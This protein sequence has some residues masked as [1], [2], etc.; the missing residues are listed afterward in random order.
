MG[1]D[2][3]IIESLVAEIWL[4]DFP[5]NSTRPSMHWHLMA[6]IDLRPPVKPRWLSYVHGNNCFS[7]CVTGLRKAIFSAQAWALQP[8][9]C[10]SPQCHSH[11]ISDKSEPHPH[12][13]VFQMLGSHD[14][15]HQRH[16]GR[17]ERDSGKVVWPHRPFKWLLCKFCWHCSSACLLKPSPAQFSEGTS[18][19][20]CH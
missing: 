16:S 14:S 12:A 11:C 13:S 19:S 1:G 2:F 3:R 5:N 4:P 8:A 20:M 18:G 10:S 7:H 9:V 17:L 15:C 6:S